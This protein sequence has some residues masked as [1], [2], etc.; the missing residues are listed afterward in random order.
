MKGVQ[1]LEW[2]STDSLL[3]TLQGI[4]TVFLSCTVGKSFSHLSVFNN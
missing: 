2:D 1:V 4:D 3:E